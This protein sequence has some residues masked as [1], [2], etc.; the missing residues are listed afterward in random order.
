[1]AKITGVPSGLPETDEMPIEIEALVKNIKNLGRRIIS[2][3]PNIPDEAA[4]F[5]ESI[6]DADYLSDLIASYMNISMK[7]KTR[8]PQYRRR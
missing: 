5:V 6:T 4:I 2:L 1:M 8:H 7:V 3:S